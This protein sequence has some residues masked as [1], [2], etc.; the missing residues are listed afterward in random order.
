MIAVLFPTQSWI[1]FKILTTLT[2]HYSDW[3]LRITATMFNQRRPK[4]A[5]VQKVEERQ[6]CPFPR[7]KSS[8]AKPH[9][10][11]QHLRIIRGGGCD[12]LHPQAHP[13]WQKLDE[14]GFL[15]LQTR[16]SGGISK[17]LKKNDMPYPRIA[18]TKSIKL[19]SSNAIASNV[20]K[21]TIPSNLPKNSSRALVFPRNHLWRLSCAACSKV[22]HRPN[23]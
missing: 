23:K 4:T 15:K 3:R 16:P 20:T 11:K 12:E 17:R 9:R 10:L 7:C 1:L 13:E 5:I 19:K 2:P 6:R 8:Y 22:F 21:L 14:N 18:I